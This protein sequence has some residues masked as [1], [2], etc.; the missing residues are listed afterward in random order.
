[1]QMTVAKQPVYALDPMPY[2]FCPVGS[3]RVS[4]LS[5][6]RRVAI[7]LRTMHIKALSRLKCRPGIE[8]WS[9]FCNTPTACMAWYSFKRFGRLMKGIRLVPC[10]PQST[11]AEPFDP[12]SPRR[13]LIHNEFRW[14]FVG[15]PQSLTPVALG[16]GAHSVT[17][18]HHAAGFR[19]VAASRYG[20]AQRA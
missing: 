10:T 16:Q 1:M 19:S 15:K 13:P 4:P 5:V 7:A 12:A 20:A 18:R 6:N 3:P 8:S 17:P 9:S 11:S 2:R 14:N